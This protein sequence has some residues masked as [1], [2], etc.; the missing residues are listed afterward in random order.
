M[1]FAMP[2]DTRLRIGR[3]GEQ[4]AAEHLER[5][6]FRIVVRNFRNRHGELDLVATDGR[7]LVFCEVKTTRA[8]AG[9]SPLDHL[10]G[11]KCRQ[12]RRMAASW[13]AESSGRERAT[14]LRFDVIGIVLDASGA[15]VGL[16]HI[17][18]AL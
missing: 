13:L 16:E 17:E 10:D 1:F 6:D 15:M 7:V 9:V 11:H 4:L 5:L 8:G 18:A 3:T 14:E 12:L 2:N